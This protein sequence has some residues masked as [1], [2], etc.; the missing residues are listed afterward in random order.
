MASVAIEGNAVH[1]DLSTLDKIWSVHGSLRIPLAH[2]KSATVE[3]ENGWDYWWRKIIGTSAPGLKT[4]GTFV[5]DGGLAFLDFGTG[6]NCVVLEMENE[7]YKFV[8]V[9]TDEDP[10]GV[11]AEINRRIGR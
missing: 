4:A 3:D 5:A 8:I 2:I 9:D 10:D 11:A 7:R 1:I 6:R